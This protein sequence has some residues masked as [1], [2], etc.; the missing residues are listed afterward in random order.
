MQRMRVATRTLS[1]SDR[2]GEGFIEGVSRVV[3]RQFCEPRLEV[4]DD[5]IKGGASVGLSVVL[6]NQSP[7]PVS[8]NRSTHLGGGGNSNPPRSRGGD[9]GDAEMDGGSATAGLQD[10]PEIVTLPDP[11]VPAKAGAADGRGGCDVAPLVDGIS[12]DGPGYFWPLP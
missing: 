11:P 4:D 1:G 7:R 2:F 6:P 12:G 5:V 10:G 9:D 8:L 3:G